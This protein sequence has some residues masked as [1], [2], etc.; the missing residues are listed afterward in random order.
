VLLMLMLRHGEASKV[1]SYFYLIPEA[2]SVDS[3]GGFPSEI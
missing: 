3:H 2:L 1:A